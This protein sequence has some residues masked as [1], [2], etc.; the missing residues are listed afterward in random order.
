MSSDKKTSAS[1]TFP[2]DLLMEIDHR[3]K[4]QDMTRSQYLR[5]LAR[6]DLAEAEKTKPK[7]DTPELPLREKHEVAA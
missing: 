4:S 6:K 2:P 1:V 7:L 5:W 3:A